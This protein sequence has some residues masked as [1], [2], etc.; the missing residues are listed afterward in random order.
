MAAGVMQINVRIPAYVGSGPLPIQVW[1]LFN[2]SQSGMTVAV[3]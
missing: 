2:V 3:Q 1:F